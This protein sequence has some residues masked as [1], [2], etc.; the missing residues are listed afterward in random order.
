MELHGLV[1]DWVDG[2]PLGER[3]IAIQLDDVEDQLERARKFYKRK[4]ANEKRYKKEYKV[5]V[6]L[7]IY[8]MPRTLGQNAFLKGLE[9]VMSMEQYGHEDGWEAYHEGLID[10]YSVDETEPNP[11][12]GRIK[13][14]RSHLLNTVQFNRLIEG[15]FIELHK[16]GLDE[17]ASA[18]RIKHY[19]IE[20]YNWRGAQEVDPLS[21]T[22]R[23]IDE[24]RSRVVWC[25][26][27][28]VAL[29]QTNEE[30]KEV[31]TGHM[32]H[33]VSR[34]A[35]GSD[36]VWNRM[37]LSGYC[38][39]ELQHAN[40]WDKLLERYPHIKWR[41]EQA[42]DRARNGANDGNET[43]GDLPVLPVPAQEREDS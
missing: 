21:E 27:S 36:E 15:A 17:Y 5:Y 29:Y 12:T 30:G 25:E 39:I 2:R 37:H 41:V 8:Y 13:R 34:G 6:S 16:M 10:A 38:H 35:G 28:G 31:Y 32:A 3:M 1:G 20:W 7:G 18:D 42:R 26:A 9:R 14:M 33:I 24:Y 4:L 23:D 22:Y 40:G 43:E 19:W 11:I